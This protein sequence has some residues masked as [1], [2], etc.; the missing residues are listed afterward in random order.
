M[1]TP[2]EVT[3]VAQQGKEHI[4]HGNPDVDD[5]IFYVSCCDELDCKAILDKLRSLSAF[6][7]HTDMTASLPLIYLH[8]KN[9]FRAFFGG[10]KR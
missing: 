10:D 1:V 9:T 4:S 2:G 6:K 3:G 7:T 8:N 5:Q